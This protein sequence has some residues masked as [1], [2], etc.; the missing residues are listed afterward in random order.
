LQPAEQRWKTHGQGGGHSPP[1]GDRDLPELQCASRWLGLAVGVLA[2]AGI[3]SLVVVIGRM[4]PFDRFVTDPLF[5]KRGLVAHVNLALVAWFYSFVAALLYLLPGA[6]APGW[7]ARHS[8]QIGAAGVAMML[9]AAGIPGTQPILSNYIPV[10]DHWLF[11]LGQA[12]FGVGVLASFVGPRLIPSA[13][14]R[15]A[16]FEIP[17]SAAMALR[18]TAIGLLLAAIT[19]GITAFRITPD[20]TV[21]VYYELLFWGGGHVLQLCCSLAMVAV[22]LILL[23]SALGRS[24]MTGKTAAILVGAMMLPWLSAPILALQGTWSPGYR[25]GFTSLMRWSIFP[26]VSLFMVACIQ[27]LMREMRAGRVSRAALADPRISGF[28][29]SVALT[30][31][32]FGLGAA[33]RGSNTMVPAHYHASIGGVTAAFMTIAYVMLHAFG[34]S[35]PTLRLRRMASWQPVLY[36]V[37]QMVFAAGFAI[38]GVYGMARKSYGA[39]QAGRGLGESIGLG[40]MGL[41]GLVAVVGGVLFLVVI[42]KIWRQGAESRIRGFKPVTEV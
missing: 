18:G 25:E 33:I 9:F 28:L 21:E 7:I 6:K 34:F 22:W 41:G 40:V 2:F 37:G 35:I 5:F 15:P 26:V 38:A 31:L 16:F 11:I 13:A 1:A 27:A 29:V 10:I 30:V 24:V 14:A 4:P 39:E 20:L 42:V 23:D 12:L 3:F 36:G 8:V 19:F 17:E 32:G